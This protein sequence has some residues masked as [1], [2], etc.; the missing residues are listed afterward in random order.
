[1]ALFPGCDAKECTVETDCDG[2]VCVLAN[3]GSYF[4]KPV[5]LDDYKEW[6][7]VNQDAVSSPSSSCSSSLSSNQM[8]ISIVEVNC[9]TYWPFFEKYHYKTHQQTDKP[10]IAKGSR[11]FLAVFNGKAI[12]ISAFLPG[13]GNF[14]IGRLVR[15]HR[16][17]VLP[18]YQGMGIGVSFVKAI[19]HSY[20]AQGKQLFF[21]VYTLVHACPRLY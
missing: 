10:S 14:G 8:N 18:A 9:T 6:H 5:V 13:M 4:N 7:H 20:V 19:G 1:M 11:A 2:T 15:E 17:V 16:T 3:D 12:A 21:V